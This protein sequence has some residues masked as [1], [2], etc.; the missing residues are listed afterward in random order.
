MDKGIL[1]QAK[2]KELYPEDHFMDAVKVE[3]WYERPVS[4]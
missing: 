2:I 1:V 3:I 4:L